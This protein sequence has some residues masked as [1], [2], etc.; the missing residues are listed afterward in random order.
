MPANHLQYQ[1]PGTKKLVHHRNR[2][3]NTKEIKNSHY[4]LDSWTQFNLVGFLNWNPIPIRLG[5]PLSTC[6]GSKLAELSIKRKFKAL[7][8][9]CEFEMQSQFLGAMPSSRRGS[10]SFLILSSLSSSTPKF[11]HC[12]VLLFKVYEQSQN[13]PPFGTLKCLINNP[14]PTG[15]VT[16]RMWTYQQGLKV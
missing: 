13:R 4:F 9:S 10:W 11:K 16:W 2:E 7:K 8:L 6:N 14:L 12:K 3:K 15:L 1:Q 5:K